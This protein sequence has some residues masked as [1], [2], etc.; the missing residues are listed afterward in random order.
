MDEMFRTFVHALLFQCTRCKEFLPIFVA[1]P[2]RN[3]ENVD[4]S[5]FDLKCK[6]GWIKK[7]R[8][9]QAL[10]HWVIPWT[11]PNDTQEAASRW[12]NRPT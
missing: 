4:G 1:M 7:L 3:L 11:N 6:C 9:M 2:E 10:R 12:G 8:G 5:T